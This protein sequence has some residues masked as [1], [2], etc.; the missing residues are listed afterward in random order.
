[1]PFK[2]S[3]DAFTALEASQIRV[4]NLWTDQRN[5]RS[6]DTPTLKE[7][8]GIVANSPWGIAGPRGMDARIVRFLHD[9]IRKTM[10]DQASRQRSHGSARRCTT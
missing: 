7:L 1:M 2:G 6:P 10:N 9:Q 8:C 4:L 5:P 3:A